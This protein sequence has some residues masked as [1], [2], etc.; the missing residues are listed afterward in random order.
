MAIDKAFYDTWTPRVLSV[1]RI[2][3]GYMMLQHGMAK[4]LHFPHVASFDDL[5]IFSL[6]GTAGIIEL[7][8]GALIL[9]PVHV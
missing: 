1:L 9:A 4:I 2:V 7:V 8:G 6:I 5:Q 3:T